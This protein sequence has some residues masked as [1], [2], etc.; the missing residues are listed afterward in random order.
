[1]SDFDLVINITRKHLSG[2]IGHRSKYGTTQESPSLHPGTGK[3]I[4]GWKWGLEKWPGIAELSQDSYT[5]SLFDAGDHI[6]YFYF[7]SGYGFDQDLLLKSISI[8]E[9][10]YQRYWIPSIQTGAYFIYNEEWYLPKLLDSLDNQTFSD[11]EIIVADNHSK[12]CTVSVAKKHGCRVVKGGLPAQGRAQGAAVAKGELLF[13]VDADCVMHPT[14]L[15]RA[16]RELSKRGIDAAG[17]LIKP[18]G[19]IFLDYL[20]FGV[21]NGFISLMQYISP[22]AA[23][24]AVFCKK[25]LYTAVGGFDKGVLLFEEHDLVKRLSK[26]GKFRIFRMLFVKTSV[27]RFTSEGRLK[28]GIQLLMSAF[29]RLLFGEIKKDTFKY[30]YDYRKD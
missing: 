1:M 7:Q 15:E 22:H 26:M 21:F 2:Q 29:Y 11:F 6:P 24:C 17:T 9:N 14:F 23:G 5:P 25:A 10:G 19:G 18:L 20:Y 13:F 4:E 27:R 3:S 28:V 30:T 12:D 8:E 16:L